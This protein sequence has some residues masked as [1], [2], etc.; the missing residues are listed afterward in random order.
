MNVLNM[1]KERI[2]TRQTDAGAI[3]RR[4]LFKSVNGGT[5][6]PAEVDELADAMREL[7][8]NT[9]QAERDTV[10]LEKAEALKAEAD[11]YAKRDRKADDERKAELEAWLHRDARIERET[12]ARIEH[13]AKRVELDAIYQRTKRPSDIERELR[14]LAADAPRVLGGE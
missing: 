12:R 9:A 8:I 1:L 11:T 6:K 5:L 7:G 4:L 14:K 2:Q 10:A 3:Y 13:E